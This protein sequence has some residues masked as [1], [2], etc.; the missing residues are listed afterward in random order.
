MHQTSFSFK[1][2]NIKE[3]PVPIDYQYLLATAHQLFIYRLDDILLRKCE[4]SIPINNARHLIDA[5]I[6]ATVIDHQIVDPTS[7]KDGIGHF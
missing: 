7:F 4:I 3:L 1:W 2:K 6:F 5:C